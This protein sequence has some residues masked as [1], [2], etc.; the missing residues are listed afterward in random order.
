VIVLGNTRRVW[1]LAAADPMAGMVAAKGIA[2]QGRDEGLARPGLCWFGGSPPL[3]TSL[4]LVS[5]S[6]GSL[7]GYSWSS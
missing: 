6:S 4:T 1:G 2:T 5:R 3:S 7:A